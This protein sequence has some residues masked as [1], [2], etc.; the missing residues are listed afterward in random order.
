MQTAMRV[1][2]ALVLGL[3]L[4]LGAL[5]A[6]TTGTSRVVR[7]VFYAPS[8]KYYEEVDVKTTMHRFARNVTALELYL[9][10]GQAR[11][12]EIVQVLRDMELAASELEGAAQASNHPFFD[13][14]LEELRRDLAN[15]RAM[16]EAN[17][18]SF[19]PAATI[20]GTCNACHRERTP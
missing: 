18:P 15:A 8:F 13:R 4:G 7:D 10:E 16:A 5:F 12:A 6:C 9:D 3:V 1:V 14:Y 17:P 19:Y 11:Q 20:T 2:G